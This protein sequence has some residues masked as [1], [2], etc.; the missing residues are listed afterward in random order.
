MICIILE[1]IP[2]Q[3]IIMFWNNIIIELLQWLVG[4]VSPFL[5]QLPVKSKK[6]MSMLSFQ[7]IELYL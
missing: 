2:T 4:A 5:T 1:A 7:V 3:C 6:V